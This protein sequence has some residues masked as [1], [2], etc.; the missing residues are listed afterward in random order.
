[1][2]HTPIAAIQLAK[3]NSTFSVQSTDHL[4][5]LDIPSHKKWTDSLG[6]LWLKAEFVAP[7][8]AYSQELLHRD[9]FIGTKLLIHQGEKERE[10]YGI[11]G[12]PKDWGQLRCHLTY[13]CRFALIYKLIVLDW[14]I[15]EWQT[16]KTTI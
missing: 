14:E 7:I 9:G 12:P 8:L 6:T 15:L 3:I 1:V 16:T 2:I 4:K 10:L 11:F 5:A 13:P